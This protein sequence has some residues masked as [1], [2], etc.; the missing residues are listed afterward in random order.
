VAGDGL[1]GA[2]RTRPPIEARLAAAGLPP[3]GRTA[4]LEIDLDALDQNLRLLR[5][6]AG[7]GVRV[8]P[9]VKADAYGHG[10][11]EVASSLEAAGA[12]GFSVATYDEAVELREAG[13]RT[14][15][16]LL[17]P[18]PAWI[19]HE[20]A[21]REIAL[22]VGDEAL[23]DRLLAAVAKDPPARPLSLAIEIETGLG[24]G[25]F[26]SR[27]AAR[28]AAT[29]RSTPALELAGTW[30]HL[31]AP[32]DA[33]RTR[34]Q[35][36]R[37]DAVLA[38]LDGD[39]AIGARH[40]AASGGLLGGAPAYDAVRPGLAIYG[41]VPE[42]VAD[43]AGAEA[44]GLRPVMALRARAVRVTELAA[45]HGVSYGPSFETERPSRVATLPLGYADGWPRAL[46]NRARALVR[47]RSVPLVGTVAMDAVMADVTDV[48]GPPVSVDDEF[49]L[50][51][52]DGDRSIDVLELARLRT[53][54]SWEAL[55][56]MSGRLTRV[57][58]RSAV[59][60]ATRSL[61]ARRSV[62]PHRALERGHL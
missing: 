45:G 55:S 7:P 16:L 27:T 34:A 13:I 51:G 24:R 42:D 44:A 43:R 25:G 5:T 30:S 19:L 3:P 53:T 28:V 11:V 48:P 57:Y 35:V 6:L 38:V 29:I 61:G 37:F 15:I 31:A 47:G 46:S 10:A 21:E 9:V 39:S 23:F 56:T 54:I 4:W 62:G 18:A 14:P 32:G 26:D 12:D 60:L 33:G 8:E 22:T 2:A 52:S 41:V 40:I 1:T 50:L 17:Y 58:H 36:S 59:P 49:T 20:A